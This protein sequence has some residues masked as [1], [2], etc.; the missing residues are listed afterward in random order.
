MQA[1]EVVDGHQIKTE[2]AN[3]R[4]ESFADQKMVKIGRRATM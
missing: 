3:V 1:A 4:V 2:A